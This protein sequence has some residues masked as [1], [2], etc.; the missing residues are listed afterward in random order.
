ML[1]YLVI[2]CSCDLVII[3]HNN[4]SSRTSHIHYIHVTLC[5]HDLLA[6]DLSSWFS[7]YCYYFQISILSNISYFLFQ[8][9]TY[10]VTAFSYSFFYYSFPSCTP[11]G[12]LLMNLYYFSVSRLESWYREMIV[13][14]ILVQLFFG[15][16]NFISWLVLLSYDGW[17][18]LWLCVSYMCFYPCAWLYMHICVLSCSLLTA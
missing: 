5:M 16:F 18:C 7:C 17:Y 8:C 9:P 11:A 12:P 10:T 13:E 2:S 3:L 1:F 4:Y 6:H 15:E 14:H